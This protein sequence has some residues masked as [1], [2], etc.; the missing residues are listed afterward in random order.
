MTRQQL[1]NQAREILNQHHIDDAPLESELL[2]RH[3][4]NINRV[5]LYLDISSDITPRQEAAFR[6]LLEKRLEGEP[7]AYIIGCRE[8]YG[9]EFYVN[10]DVLIP[11]PETELLVDQ[12]LNLAKNHRRPAIAEIG[13][14]CGAIAIALALHLPEARIY[15]ID[16]SAAALK[17]ASRNCEN[18]RVTGKV[19]LLHG[20]MLE[21]VPQPVDL[22]IANLPYVKQ[23][24]LNQVNTFGYEPALALDG[25]IDGLDKIRRLC[26]QLND[27]LNTDGHLLLEIG[28][29]QRETVTSLLSRSFPSAEVAFTPDLSGIDRVVSLARSPAA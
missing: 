25:G 22:V 5:Q 20:N 13:T 6:R 3:T 7:A 4:L 15:G 18:H 2:L 28:L 19:T 21:P 16:I 11:R 17:V 14:G 8:F 12:A 10:R 27:R 23:A 26:R 29:G 9:L 24:D 1:L